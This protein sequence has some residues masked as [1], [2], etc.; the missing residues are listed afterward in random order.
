MFRLRKLL[1]KLDIHIVIQDDQD[2]IEYEEADLSSDNVRPTQELGQSSATRSRRASFND[3]RLDE[4]WL[5]GGRLDP[6]HSAHS[7]R[8]SLDDLSRRQGP[9]VNALR[10]SRA[11]AILC[12]LK[13]VSGP[14]DHQFLNPGFVTSPLLTIRM[15]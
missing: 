1:A 12:R 11:E 14:P 5:S 3:T 7:P 6:A 8:A 10:R 4:T 9:S 2:A 15:V 13:A